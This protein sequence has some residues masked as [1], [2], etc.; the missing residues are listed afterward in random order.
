MPEI[1]YTL[2]KA[3]SVGDVNRM[4]E[5]RSPCDGRAARRRGFFH[6]RMETDS[7]DTMQSAVR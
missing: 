7:T 5:A 6:H 4:I 2:R 1:V 3:D